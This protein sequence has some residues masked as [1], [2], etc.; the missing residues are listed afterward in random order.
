M[1][2]PRGHGAADGKP[3]R[4]SVLECLQHHNPN[5]VLDIA[6]GDGWLGR[7]HSALYRLDGV[8]FFRGAP[9]GYDNFHACDLNQGLP[10]HLGKY[11]AIVCCEAV[12]YL[13]NPGLL[14][15][16]V[17]AHL[18]PAGR[19]ILSTPNPTYAGNRV[20]LIQHGYFS[21]FSR[22]IENSQLSPHMPWHALGWPQLWLLLGL[23]GLSDIRL[24][25]VPERKPKRLLEYLPGLLAKAYCRHRMGT[26]ATGNERLF[27]KY[28]GSDQ[29]VYGRRLVVSA[30]RAA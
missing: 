28:F 22:F 19:F 30:R 29:C 2:E 14:F 27:W 7:S 16:S 1:M 8:D 11:D 17:H 15:S 10:A 6:C 18:N 24:H 12:A 26:S 13:T 21:G 25:D 9:E 20:F 3:Y 5:S 4:A 23:S